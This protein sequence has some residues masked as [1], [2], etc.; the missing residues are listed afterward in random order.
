ME[1][2]LISHG[3]GA[4]RRL[5]VN[6][7]T[8][9][10]FG[11]AV[12]LLIGLTAYTGFKSGA[13]WMVSRISGDERF[14]SQLWQQEISQDR[15]AIAATRNDIDGALSAIASRVG[16]LQADMTRLD[17]V[18]VRVIDMAGM[19]AG[20]F[21]LESE[22]PVG[23][24]EVPVSLDWRTTLSAIEDLSATLSVQ[25]DQLAAIESL[26]LNRELSD[27][28][29]PSGL[30][31]SSGWIS[32]GYGYRTDPLSGGR[33]FHAGVDLAGRSGSTVKAVAD[34]VVTWSGPR[35]GYGN[36]VEVTHGNG[37]VTRYAH[38]RENTV[39]VGEKV[40]KDQA[41]A[42][43]GSSGRSTGP[44]VHFEVLK[45]GKSV[46]PNQYLNSRRG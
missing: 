23:G 30:P 43:L 45:D 14:A 9:T 20:E 42:L 2:I 39:A 7:A 32:S 46:N 10:S 36:M 25:D 8:V 40:E 15:A 3:R 41:I 5:R 33:A 27:S 18:A 24:P 6:T 34:G 13:D 16:M 37:F 19:D 11:V 4:T 28:I 21:S 26:L 44:H 1:I 12:A 22:P 35:P 31:V 17:A 29:L 38:N